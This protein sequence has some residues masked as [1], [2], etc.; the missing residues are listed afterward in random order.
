MPNITDKSGNSGVNKKFN[1]KFPNWTKLSKDKQKR[2]LNA[3][4]ILYFY[5]KQNTFFKKF[6]RGFRKGSYSFA[7]TFLISESQIIIIT[8]QN[9]LFDIAFSKTLS[10]SEKNEVDEVNEVNELIA[11]LEEKER[12]RLQYAEME[13]KREEEIQKRINACR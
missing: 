6:C 8:L 10:S 4:C 9:E 7:D 11:E 12:L 3:F 2:L 5:K 13:K 1:K